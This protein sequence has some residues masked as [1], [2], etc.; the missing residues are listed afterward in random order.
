LIN[1]LG[2]VHLSFNRLEYNKQYEEWYP[3][4]SPSSVEGEHGSITYPKEGEGALRLKITLSVRF[5]FFSF[6][7]LF[8]FFSFFKPLI[9]GN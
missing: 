6:S 4:L 5:L 8:L 2:K 9:V 1:L 3:L 7:F